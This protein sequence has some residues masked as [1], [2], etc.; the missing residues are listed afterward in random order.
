[1]E[2]FDPT[3]HNDGQRRFVA[4]ALLNCPD[5]QLQ[6]DIWPT[7]QP[8]RMIRFTRDN[9]GVWQ[10]LPKNTNQPTQLPNELL[11]EWATPED[12]S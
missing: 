11:R 1:M 12:V 2:R 4:R 3:E 9:D 5:D 7:W 8:E 6:K 10:Y